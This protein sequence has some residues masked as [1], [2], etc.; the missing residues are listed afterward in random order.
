MSK[1]PWNRYNKLCVDIRKSAL[2]EFVKDT[3][4]DRM[5]DMSATD[6]VK[7]IEKEFRQKL[8]KHKE[9]ERTGRF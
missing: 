4:F 5:R 3:L 1:I 7:I 6:A 9:W 2:P 8:K